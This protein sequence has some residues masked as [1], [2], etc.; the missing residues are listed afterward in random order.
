MPQMVG[1]HIEHRRHI[2]QRHAHAGAKRSTPGDFEHGRGRCSRSASTMRV[3]T[4]P[5]GRLDGSL[6]VD[7]HAVGRRQ[8]GG[9][10]RPSS[11]CA[12]ALRAVVVLPLVPVMQ[13]IRH[14]GGRARRNNMSINGP[15]AS[16]RRA[17][18]RRHVHAKAGRR[19][20]FANSPAPRSCS[21]PRYRDTGNP[22]R[23]RRARMA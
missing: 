1:L 17:F 13:A 16:P 22:R 5:S 14:P 18:A 6:A 8:S 23:P 4:G 21:S 15:A 19:I 11:R 12:P 20:D 9:E 10:G 2:R 3:A 7:V